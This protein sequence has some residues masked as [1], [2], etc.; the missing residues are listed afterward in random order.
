[1]TSPQPRRGPFV[2]GDLVQLSDAKGR[3]HT[4]TLVPGKEFHTHRG[5]L[6]HDAVIG[7]P[8]GS[9]HT[10][11]GGTTYVA[12]RPLLDDFALSMPR[13]AAVVYPKDAA[14]IVSL[15]N[16]GARMRVVEAG[17]GS[18]ALTCWLLRA[19][20][21]D[22]FVRSYERRSEFGE[23]AAANI[24]TWFGGQPSNWEL[25]LEDLAQA[26]TQVPFDAA[27]LDM[28]APWDCLDAVDRIV[29][30]GGVLV[31][32]VTTTTQLSRLVE[33][34]RESEHWTEPRAEESLVRT[35][36]LDGL[37]VRP[38]HRMIGHSGFL[39][40]A[41]HLAPGHSAPQRRRRPA[42]G[43][44]GADYAGPGAG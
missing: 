27:V 16:L 26:Q 9:V 43:A 5:H 42:P 35:W 15:A 7:S 4:I 2:P 34:M 41:R 38:D 17:V 6:K 21:E 18:G 1:M 44:Y 13:G 32:Y 30:P 14:R 39:V 12:L 10:A 8:E 36:H 24:H 20:G 29:R 28:V 22:G 11:T 37:A 40:T 33:T 23:V 3:L 25:V 19:V 31:A